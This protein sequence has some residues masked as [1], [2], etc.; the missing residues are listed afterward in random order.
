MNIDGLFDGTNLILCTNM[1]TH[2]PTNNNIIN[3]FLQAHSRAFIL[4]TMFS[5][6]NLKIST[7]ILHKQAINISKPKDNSHNNNMLSI[8]SVFMYILNEFYRII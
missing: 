5:I 6:R 2:R 1:Q 3:S 8:I 7:K 4:G